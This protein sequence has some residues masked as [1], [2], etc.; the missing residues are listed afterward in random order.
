MDRQFLTRGIRIRDYLYLLGLVLVR[1]VKRG[2]MPGPMII[3]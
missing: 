2:V 1:R 3:S